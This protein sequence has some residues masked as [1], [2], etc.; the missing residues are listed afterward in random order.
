MQLSNPSAGTAQGAA[1][2]MILNDDSGFAIVADTPSLAEGN[3]G[4]TPFT[5]TVSRLGIA[6]GS[7]S[8]VWVTIGA[9]TSS[10]SP[11][12]FAGGIAPAGTLS[13]GPGQTSQTI[14]V[15]VQGDTLAEADENFRVL[16]SRPSAGSSIVTGSAEATIRNDDT[17]YT[18]AADT[19]ALAE[20]DGGITPFS[21]TVTRIGDTSGAGSVAWFTSGLGPHS[22]SL[23]DLAGG[24]APSGTLAFTAGQTS[25]TITVNIAGDTL[26]E[27]D[28]WFTVRLATPSDGAGL[29]TASAAAE[30]LNDD[31]GF[32][33]AALDA[34]KQEGNAGVT[35]FTF[36]VTRSGD[37][38]GSD[39]IGW[40]VSGMPGNSASV[41]DFAGGAAPGG[42]LTF[43][44]GVAAQ[45][46]TIEVRGDTTA[47]PDENFLVQLHSPST[48]VILASLAGGQILNDDGVGPLPAGAIAGSL[49]PVATAD[50]NGDGT[51]D[52][53]RQAAGG[54]L[55][56]LDGA[57]ASMAALPGSTGMQFIAAT[58][59]DQD[60]CADL[61]LRDATGGLHAW[62]MHG[63]SVLHDDLL[64]TPSPSSSLSVGEAGAAPAI[65]LHDPTAVHPY[66]LFTIGTGN[67]VT[68]TPLDTPPI[69]WHG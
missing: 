11:S 56:L 18:I 10:A 42:T 9:S 58:D 64:A 68:T 52:L 20:G 60:G 66:A 46:L 15:N 23:G 59:L 36:T 38:T 13:F 17:G 55:Y 21:F 6:D 25:R 12:D 7:A 5:F 16:L 57:T 24:I 33:I 14:T 8:V 27:P 61:L 19:P 26:V 43:L 3:A 34:V 37:L 4:V 47:E 44:P 41:S 40:R 48:G 31:A 29:I 65:L 63:A 32:S 53:L 50:F 54:A 30:V 49:M 67:V 22:I 62:L 69:G 35:P 39:S 1:V 2:G 51:T 45:T 28:E